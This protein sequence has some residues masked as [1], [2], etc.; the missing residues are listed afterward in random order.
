MFLFALVLCSLITYTSQS[1]NSVFPQVPLYLNPTTSSSPDDNTS[2]DGIKNLVQRRL[3]DHTQAFNFNLVPSSG[4]E[5][6]ISDSATST[7]GITIQCS[8]SN[9]CARGLYTYLKDFGGVDIWWTGSRL[10]QLASP[11]PKVGTPVKGSS[12]VDYRYYFNTVTFSY[13]TAFYTFDQWSFLLDWMALKGVNLPLA[14]VGYEYIFLQT[15]KQVGMS[16]QDVISFFSGPAFQAW[17][18]FGNI[19]GSWDGGSGESGLPLQWINDQF[20]LQKQ[21]IARMVELGMTPILPAFT[22]FLPCSI[23]TLYPNATVVNNKNWGG[24]PDNLTSDCFLLPTDPLFT[25]IQKIFIQ[26]Q[27][28]AYGNVTNMYTLDQYNEM[29][30]SNETECSES[31]LQNISSNTFQSLREADSKAIWIMQGWSFSIFSWFWTNDCISAYLGGVSDPNGMLILDLY[32]EAQPQWQRTSSYEGRPWI[33]CE[34]HDF[35][36]N[37]GFE[38]YLLNVTVSPIEALHSPNST[39][40]G[41]GLTMEGQEGNEI[42]YD[43]LLDQAW[44]TFPLSIPQ[45]VTSWVDRRYQLSENTSRTAWNDV[46]TAWS[47]LSS[48]VYN[49]SDPGTQATVKSI[50]ELAPALSGLVNL[51]LPDYHPTEIFYDTNTTILPALNSLLQAKSEY[52]PLGQVPEFQYDAVDLTRQ[53]LANRFQVVYEELVEQYTNSNITSDT[54]AN[55]SQHLQDI[56]SNLDTLL[57]TNPNFLLSTWIQSATN[58]SSEGTNGSYTRYLEYNARNQITLWGPTGEINDYASRQWAGLV[59]TYY[60]PRWKMFTDYLI[61]TKGNNETYNGTVISNQILKFGLDWDM[62]T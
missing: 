36:Q 7:P 8:S 59:G 4:D 22:G 50:L 47:L 27:K 20:A 12:I 10:S 33:W 54:L 28:T 9:A 30:P 46:Q 52:S 38:G 14:W 13:T 19:Q 37:Q 25:K 49:N 56:L 17:N 40:K 18:R 6:E 43:I 41:I 35:G 60:L 21:I 2:L 32:S 16:E 5:F 61:K 26:N 51:T 34:L 42:V 53:L 39:M 31:D 55:T 1:V 58:W 3:P 23:T 29:L 24:F 44:S 11:L 48:T 45:Y 57:Y 62:R 15:L